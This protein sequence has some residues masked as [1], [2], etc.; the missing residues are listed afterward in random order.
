MNGIP[1]LSLFPI[2]VSETKA[3]ATD[4]R[5]S[6]RIAD[7]AILWLFLGLTVVLARFV[8]TTFDD[9]HNLI[10]QYAGIGSRTAGY[11]L[12]RDPNIYAPWSMQFGVFKRCDIC[13]QD[14][15]PPAG[16]AVT[17]VAVPHNGSAVAVKEDALVVVLFLSCSFHTPSQDH[18]AALVAAQEKDAR[19]TATIEVKFDR[20][21]ELGV[22]VGSMK[23][24]LADGEV[25]DG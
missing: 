24:H 3:I 1:R 14:T 5:Y 17:S 15:S 8:P 23:G 13:R 9:I 4:L 21:G 22:E 2:A 25:L 6:L 7:P 12:M 11:S 16:K 18:R 19:P 20:Q 10:F